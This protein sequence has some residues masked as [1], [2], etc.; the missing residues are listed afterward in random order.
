MSTHNICFHGKIRKLYVNTL[1]SEAIGYYKYS[2]TG[3]L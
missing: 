2:D 1:V 3:V